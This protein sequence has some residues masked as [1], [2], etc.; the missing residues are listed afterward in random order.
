MLRGGSAVHVALCQIVP[1]EGVGVGGRDADLMRILE[2]KVHRLV[3]RGGLRRLG[4]V[5]VRAAFG[6]G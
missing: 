3:V 5:R 4:R 1:E 6:D 2:G